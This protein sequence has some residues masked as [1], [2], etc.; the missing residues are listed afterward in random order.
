PGVWGP[1]RLLQLLQRTARP[2]PEHPQPSASTRMRTERL[3]SRKNWTLL[4]PLCPSGHATAH[5]SSV[6]LRV[7]LAV[8]WAHFPVLKGTQGTAEWVSWWQEDPPRSSQG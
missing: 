6:L 4:S 5:L 1:E 7:D 8:S 2:T 3:L